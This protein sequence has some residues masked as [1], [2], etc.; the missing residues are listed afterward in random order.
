MVSESRTVRFLR[1]VVK[2]KSLWVVALVLAFVWFNNSSLF[3]GERDGKATIVAHAALGQSYDLKGVKW[4][5]NTAAIIHTPEHNYIENTLPS[6]QAAF[7]YG[8]DIVEFDVRLTG[9]K[10]LAV[11]HDD[12]LAYR[13]NAKGPVSAFTMEQLRHIDVGYGYTAD[14][15][16]TYPLR[17]TGIG[18]MVSID[19]VFR[20]FP[21]GKFL[22]HIKDGG[23]QIGPI[24]LKF[25]STRD[26]SEIENISVYGNDVALNLLRERYPRMKLLSAGKIKRA[27]LSYELIGWTGIVPGPMRNMELHFPVRYAKFLW[28]WPNRFLQRMN[29]VNS[30]VVLVQYVDGWSDGFDSRADLEMLPKGYTGAVWTNRVDIIGPLLKE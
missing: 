7:A 14:G 6:M 26:A 16:Q 2:K 1:R 22:I 9:D 5:T 23:S 13:T 25:L 29:A 15:G 28:G 19:D 12:I 18:L 4:N 11:F 8:A 3:V 27:L 20:R 24:L 17:G 21:N 30:R 10:Q